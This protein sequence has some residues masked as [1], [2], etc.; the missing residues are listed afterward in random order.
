[1]GNKKSAR[2]STKKT[3]MKS[4]KQR[5]SRGAKKKGSS[6]PAVE[7]RPDAAAEPPVWMA[8]AAREEDA[9]V[10]PPDESPVPAPTTESAAARD[11]SPASTVPTPTASTTEAQPSHRTAIKHHAKGHFEKWALYY[12]RS[13]LNEVVFFPSIRRCQE[14]ILRWRQARPELPY[15]MLDI[16]CGTGTLLSIQARDP[17]CEKLVGL[18]YAEEMVRRCATKFEESEFA[19]KLLAIRGDAEHLPFAD[20]SF[21]VITCCNSFHHYPH[22]ASA[23]AEFRRVLRPDG[24]LVLIDGFR[25]NVIGWLIFDLCVANFEKHVHH[26]SWTE[27][28]SMFRDAGLV[29]HQQRKMNV[30]APLLVNTAVC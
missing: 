3:G 2:K 16:G 29:R 17:Y 8:D 23:V 30:L 9:P 1:M 25:D 22:Q 7:P 28:R 20:A 26:A 12:D 18:D 15:R 10:S 14:E 5:R 11:D 21:D 4:G 19:D 6:T 13:W 27:F 24:L